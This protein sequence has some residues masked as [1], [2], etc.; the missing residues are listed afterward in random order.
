MRAKPSR[1]VIAG[2]RHVN[3]VFT[4]LSIWYIQINTIHL[5]FCVTFANAVSVSNKSRG[6]RMKCKNCTLEIK[7]VAWKGRPRWI[8]YFDGRLWAHRCPSPLRT[9]AKPQSEEQTNQLSPL[10]LPCGQIKDIDISIPF[11]IHACK[12][13]KGHGYLHECVCHVTWI[14]A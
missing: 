2:I 11:P 8:H 7:F 5:P 4:G 14:S 1:F 13:A 12:L 9:S 3:T 10:P 6:D